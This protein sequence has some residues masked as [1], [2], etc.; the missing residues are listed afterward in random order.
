MRSAVSCVNFPERPLRALET[1]LWDTPAS[2]ATSLI[3]AC[4]TLGPRG[5]ASSPKARPYQWKRLAAAP[6]CDGP[7]PGTPIRSGFSNTIY[8][9][10]LA[11]DLHVNDGSHRD[12][13][14][15][16]GPRATC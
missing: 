14:R 1:V 6:A 7:R 4:F 11:R 16:A 3:V 8:Q 10:V 9:K 13:P 5:A 12:T 15:S 2:R